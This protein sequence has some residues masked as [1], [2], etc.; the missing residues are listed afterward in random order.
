MFPLLRFIYI[1][2]FLCRVILKNK[3][4]SFEALS[5]P[6]RLW[7][8]CLLFCVFWMPTR[9]CT[10]LL[11]IRE[12]CVHVCVGECFLFMIEIPYDKIMQFFLFELYVFNVQ[13]FYNEFLEIS[14]DESYRNINVSFLVTFLAL[15]F[16][17]IMVATTTSKI[18][19]WSY[20]TGNNFQYRIY[21]NHLELT[22]TSTTICSG[23]P[24]KNCYRYAGFSLS[25]VI[26]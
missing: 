4:K 7:K 5:F 25:K 24:D 16:I 3:N 19:I 6:Y 9:A 1:S 18:V 23:F 15:L 2:F 10:Y 11:T 8:G 20:R 17:K 12:N 22:L 13:H 26:I 21:A 14:N